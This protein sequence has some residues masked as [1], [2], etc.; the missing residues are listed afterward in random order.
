MATGHNCHV[1]ISGKWMPISGS[2]QKSNHKVVGF[3]QQKYGFTSRSIIFHLHGDV[4][5]TGEGLQNLHLC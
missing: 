4:P 2:I 5:I 1:Y 3:G